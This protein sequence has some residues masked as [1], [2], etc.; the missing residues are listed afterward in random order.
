MRAEYGAGSFGRHLD[1]ALRSGAP[2]SVRL[3]THLS[4]DVDTIADCRHPEVAPLLRSA[5]IAI[6]GGPLT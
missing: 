3:D 5:G 1:A 2:V 6:D 4:I